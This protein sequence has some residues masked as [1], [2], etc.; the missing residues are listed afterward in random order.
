[1]HLGRLRIIALLIVAGVATV[2]SS[3]RAADLCRVTSI[4]VDTSLANNSG[5]TLHDS[6]GQTFL[7]PDTLMTSLTVWP[8]PG[9][10]N[11]YPV[12]AVLVGTDSTG[13]PTSPRLWEGPALTPS[14]STAFTWTMDP[15]LALPHAGRYAWFVCSGDVQLMVVSGPDAYP[16]GQ[17][18]STCRGQC[19]PGCSHP[20]NADFVFTV[21]FCSDRATA[22]RRHTWGQLKTIYR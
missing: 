6:V 9:G 20:Q 7:T 15:P 18:W 19:G 11:Y 10:I 13:V 16:D 21:T 14:G 3:A 1:M 17:A 2:I 8:T 22:T 4:S 5:G 12:S